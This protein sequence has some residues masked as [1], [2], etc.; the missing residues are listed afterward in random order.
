[1][2]N[3]KPI[4]DPT[5]GYSPNNPYNLRDPRLALVVN[6]NG[7]LFKNR[8]VETFVDGA[9]GLNK[10]VNATKTGY[11]MRKFLSE[12]A[13]WNQAANTSVRRPWVVFRYAE[14]LLN[15][16]EALNEVQGPVADVYKSVNLIRQRT[17]IAMPALPTGLTKEQMRTR[18]QNERR[19]ELCFEGHRF[20]DIR[21][22][23]QGDLFLNKPVTGMKIEKSSTNVL[24]F[25]RF[26]VEQRVFADKNYLFPISQN[27]INRQPA[28]IQN[29]GY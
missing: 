9:D 15:Y 12:S 19:V 21:R 17:G 25:T 1:M 16:A 10:N 7:R 26:Q 11:Y 22:W 8:A 3:G 20:F 23:K 5:S 13:T 29:G 4:S 18:I 14:I 27:D 2:T 24:T 6:F 28:L